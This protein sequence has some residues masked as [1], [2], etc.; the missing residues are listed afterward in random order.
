MNARNLFNLEGK[1]A[2]VTGGTG[3]LGRSMSEGLAEAGAHVYITSRDKEKALIT[4]NS[5]SN[6]IEDKVDVEVLDNLSTESVKNCFNRIK[7]NSNKID[8]LVNNAGSTSSANFENMSEED[9]ETGINNTINGVFRC[10]REVIPIM[11]KNGEGSIINISSMYG[12]VSPDPSIYEE[13]GFNSLPSYGA[14]KAAIIQYTKFLACHLAKKRI[15]VN[16][17]SPGP[18]PQEDVQKNVEFINRL[19]KKIPMG[20]IGLPDELKGIMIFLA[21]DASSYITGENILVDGG[22]TAW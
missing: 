20:R 16:S 19:K 9:W 1:V 17:V 13:S 15:R 7:N 4:K 21:S 8:I 14:G 2:V 11:E 6:E 18:F 12:K 5:F 10:T 22:W 3:H